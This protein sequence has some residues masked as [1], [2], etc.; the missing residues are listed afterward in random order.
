MDHI[1]I[2]YL[3]ECLGWP[4]E[5][6]T[7]V[8]LY[9][10]VF[11]PAFSFTS[12]YVATLC[13]YVVCC[14]LPD[15][16]PTGT[17][18]GGPWLSYENTYILPFFPVRMCDKY[19]GLSLGITR[20]PAWSICPQVRDYSCMRCGSCFKQPCSRLPLD[21]GEI[22]LSFWVIACKCVCPLDIC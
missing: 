16:V 13:R 18:A 22:L 10:G 20:A 1:C 19:R 12:I 21:A 4:I 8:F 11:R 5:A 15:R 6:L 3:R 7:T 14:G 2:A 9:L 17:M